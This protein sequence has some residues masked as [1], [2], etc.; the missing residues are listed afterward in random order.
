MASASSWAPRRSNCAQHQPHFP[1]SVDKSESAKASIGT[2]YQSQ[3]QQRGPGAAEKKDFDYS[4]FREDIGTHYRGNK[5][6]K[7]QPVASKGQPIFFLYRGL[8]AANAGAPTLGTHVFDS[9]GGKRI[10]SSYPCD[11][12]GIEIAFNC[13]HHKSGVQRGADV[14]SQGAGGGVGASAGEGAGC[15]CITANVHHAD[16]QALVQVGLTAVTTRP[17]CGRG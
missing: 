4:P 13:K 9:N 14:E 6:D 7:G 2:T 3:G 5:G 10:Q 17:G 12:D 15:P 8:N 11:K 16:W 1:S